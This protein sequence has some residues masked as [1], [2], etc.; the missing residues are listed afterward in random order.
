M[1]TK[2]ILD[3]RKREREGQS[4]CC[5]W[6]HTRTKRLSRKITRDIGQRGYIGSSAGTAASAARLCCSVGARCWARRSCSTSSFSVLFGSRV[7]FNSWKCEKLKFA[8]NGTFVK[9][10]L[11]KL[12][13]LDADYF[14]RWT[15][16]TLEGKMTLNLRQCGIM[17]SENVY[18]VESG[19]LLVLPGCW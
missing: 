11:K 5:C 2:Q 14:V 15:E 18:H 7:L 9:V 4:F 13:V 6:K 17:S 12:L 10:L 8:G 1:E 16:E 3:V 19:P